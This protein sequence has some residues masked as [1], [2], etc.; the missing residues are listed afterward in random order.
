LKERKDNM[1]KKPFLKAKPRELKKISEKAVVV[2]SYNG[3]E[4]ILPISQI[5][6]GLDCIYIPTWLAEKKKVQ[7]AN[8]TYWL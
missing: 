2:K 5:R 7:C 3:E 6:E 8:K 1:K 4:D